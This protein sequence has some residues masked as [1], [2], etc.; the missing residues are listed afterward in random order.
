MNKK[1]GRHA[2][3]TD[4]L[5]TLADIARQSLI[6]SD[7]ITFVQMVELFPKLD[8]GPFLEDLARRIIAL[9]KLAVTRQPYTTFL[10]WTSLY[11]D[12]YTWL[13]MPDIFVLI[14]R[15]R[16]HGYIPKSS[17]IHQ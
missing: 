5:G 10:V 1:V 3:G 15:L 6:K 13:N 7:N 12:G 14:A 9:T 2:R 16:R 11:L 8:T 4:H 17:P